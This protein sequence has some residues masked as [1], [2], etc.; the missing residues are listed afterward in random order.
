MDADTQDLLRGSIRE[1]LASSN[2]DIV[3]GLNDLGWDDVV[4]EAPDIAVDLLFTEQGAAG[5]SSSA[6]DT[7][8]YATDATGTTHPVLHPFGSSE[9]ARI[10]GARLD[11]D[12]VFLATPS[13]AAAVIGAD[14]GRAYLIDGPALSAA[15]TGVAGFDP[16]SRLHRVQL[17][18]DTECA[19]VLDVE[20]P[21]VVTVARRALAAELIGNGGAMLKLAAAQISDRQQFG[22]PIGANQSPRH[23]LAESYALLGGA[24]ELVRM[25]WHSGSVWD[26]RVAKAYAGY[27]VDATSRACLQVCG[28]I[29]LTTEH[30]LPG[31][32]QRARILDALYGGWARGVEELGTDILA[33]VAVPPGDR[34]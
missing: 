2:G 21:R 6:L 19:A 3:D 14:D 7:V 15:A 17:T 29:G 22:R 1:M 23:R 10:R 25:A 16:A 13:A 31:F 28:A 5:R 34:L 11:I 32:V 33:A 18:V 27:A 4:A 8:A 26:A 9:G 30:L 12:A 24:T 20:W